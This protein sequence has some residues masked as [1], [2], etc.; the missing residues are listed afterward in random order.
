[1]RERSRFREVLEQAELK[2]L[3][4]KSLNATPHE[5]E[6]VLAKEAATTL[7]DVAVL[8]SPVAW[9]RYRRELIRISHRLT[10]CRFG[11]TVHL[12]AP[13]YLS[14]ECHNICTYCGFS[15]T[16]KFPRVTLTMEQIRQ[17]AAYLHSVG[18][19]HVLAVTG[20]AW[21]SVTPEYI[22]DAVTT[23]REFFCHVSI[24][25][26]PLDTHHYAMLRKRGVHAVVV[27]QETY[28]PTAY[29][30]WHLKGRKANYEYR[31]GTPER[32][33]TARIRKVGLGILL[34][35]ND[36]REDA[37]ALALHL[38]WLKRH[39]WQTAYSVAFPRMRPA[40]GALP[41]E[42]HVSDG[43]LAQLVCAFRLFDPD[44]EI[45]LSTREPAS[46]RE[47]LVLI[48]VTTMSA[49]SATNPGGYTIYPER[50][51]LEQFEICDERPPAQVCEALRQLNYE[52]VWKDWEE[53]L[54]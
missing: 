31:L 36:W 38:D 15:L 19:E 26:Q 6:R 13:L 20:E 35:L 34:G 53:A 7:E 25:T 45:V 42:V 12:F 22:A 18:F 49:G 21:T 33:A 1:M 5:V 3:V 24:E 28:N 37:L 27:Y 9:S 50:K 8:L 41:P 30:K 4:H 48:G 11:Y 40:P 52:P 2:Q 29:R 32:A 23:L 47:K 44:V 43:Q 54:V 16:N 39:H 46:L 14:N 51:S 10:V 17:E